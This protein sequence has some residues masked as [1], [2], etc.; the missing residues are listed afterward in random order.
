MLGPRRKV[1][2]A[3]FFSKSRQ[4]IPIFGRTPTNSYKT[5]DWRCTVNPSDFSI[6]NTLLFSFAILTLVV[7]FSRMAA[8]KGFQSGPPEYQVGVGPFF[9]IAADLHKTGRKDL[10][11][12]NSAVSNG[13]GTSNTISVLLS[14]PDG[15]YQ[16]AVTYAVGNNPIG[17]AVGDFIGN[18]KLDL[19]VA[20]V[21]DNTIS[22]L[23]GNGD[24][25]FQEPAAHTIASGGPNPIGIYAAD[26]R[27]VGKLDLVVMNSDFVGADS[28]AT[29]NVSVLLGNGN[30]TFGSPTKVATGLCPFIGAVT[31]LGNGN[32]DIVF[33]NTGG[34]NANSS[35]SIGV[36]VGNGTGSFASEVDY[37]VGS[38]PQD[39]AIA[40]FNG[41]GKLDVVVACKGDKNTG[42][43]GGV[44]LLTGNGNGT[45]NAASFISGTT[46]NTPK[47]IAVADFNGDGKAD[48]AIIQTNTNGA[49][50]LFLGNGNG[51][52][53]T[54][55]TISAPNG[56]NGS[57]GSLTA[58]DLN[59]DGKQDLAVLIDNSPNPGDVAVLLGNG[60]GTFKGVIN[61]YNFGNG[62]APQSVAVADFNNDNKPDL[63][64][65]LTNFNGTESSSA[66][67]L[68]GNGDGT[69][70]Q[71]SPISLLNNN[72][73]GG[74]ATGI[75]KNG[76]HQDI[77]VSQNSQAGNGF[78]SYLAG[79]GN[80]TF[81][82]PVNTSLTINPFQ[83]AAADF[84][85]NGN[86]DVAVGS[87]G[88]LDFFLGN[89]N[90]TFGAANQLPANGF[91]L[92]GQV[93]I[94]DLNA[95]GFPDIVVANVDNS[96]NLDAYVYLNNGGGGFT[97][98]VVYLI[99]P[100][101]S[102]F[103]AFG[104]ALGHFKETTSAGHLDIAVTNPK[105]N[106]V[107]ILTNNG[108][109]TF[110]VGS[111]YPVGTNPVYIATG[112]FHGTGHT[113]LA[114]ANCTNCSMSNGAGSTVN[115]LYG[116]G[117]G[118]FAL[119][120]INYVAGNG[121]VAIG[122]GD[123]NGDGAP[124]LAVAN[125]MDNAVTILLNTGGTF[126]N[127]SSSATPITYGQSVTFTASIMPSIAGT[128][129][130]TGSFTFKDG[131]TVLAT[132]AIAAGKAVYMTTTLSA[133]AHSIT[134][135]YSGD[136]SFNPHTST[137]L[138][139]T[140][141]QAGT[142]TVVQSSANPSTPGQQVTFTA[143]VSPAAT[144]IPTGSVNFF[145]GAAM[146]GSGVLN[147]AAQAT[148]QPAG[149]IVGNH[150]ITAQYTGDSNFIGSTS[151]ILTQI[152]SKAPATTMVTSDSPNPSIP[153]QMVTTNISVTSSGGGTPTGTITLSLNGSQVGLTT[154]L[155]S[156][157][158]A[159][160]WATPALAQGSYPLV[161]TYSGDATHAVS[162]SQ[163]YSHLVNSAAAATTTT[164]L[165]FAVAPA[166]SGQK[167]GTVNSLQTITL[168]ANVTSMT[169]GT[170][171]GTITFYDEGAALGNPV[172]VTN[173]Q[174]AL[175]ALR[176]KTGRHDFVAVSSGDAT[177]GGSISNPPTSLEV[178]PKPR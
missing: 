27:G 19:A 122:V 105:T 165:M 116:N 121:S 14:N 128:G 75:F 103:Q 136:S 61:S 97:G 158:A 111:S 164:M 57:D 34:Q 108:N 134:A 9:S 152:V 120:P 127:L 142:A 145:D 170:I 80:G 95:D 168:T 29:G 176:L 64:V 109:G 65:G 79:N 94:G 48:F 81:Q 49:G 23:L 102:N 143:T 150:S 1:I 66:A 148:F 132:V 117:D 151:P 131:A 4:S 119:D 12:A 68:L 101:P 159:I 56:T 138:I 83:I 78:L 51:T 166:H 39:M 73:V 161:A 11:V 88:G 115:I 10:I 25:T 124:D 163:N 91:C 69:F 24:G 33:V 37:A 40:D 110:T 53:Q 100:G 118:T 55:K 171:G 76:G 137:A 86:L 140:V 87:C 156:G 5:D 77:V 38:R 45:F 6:R 141:Q 71:G 82:A 36:L 13:I 157:T 63:A 20:N 96:G 153:A 47:S 7:T 173:G 107:T 22:I 43:N 35:E 90:G 8:A 17:I 139:E 104:V 172:P 135:V 59:G 125:S 169:A 123:Y 15:T 160:T 147:G 74:I 146:I 84:D 162:V 106:T 126:L 41:D 92:G 60:N 177:F 2:N 72:G 113:D 32:Q 155:S 42:A 52:F 167:P 58:A 85:K 149:L 99:G 98:P 175:P 31:N 3:L 62:N 67:V 28:C 46:L 26:L 114:V 130:P 178:T 144:G 112:D 21:K 93:A 30:G 44:D 50:A 174:A 129:T 89:G 133:G 70:T 18:G 16:A 154:P 54:P